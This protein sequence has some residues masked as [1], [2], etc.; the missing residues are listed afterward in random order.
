M[1]NEPTIRLNLGIEGKDEIGANPRTQKSNTQRDTL[2]SEPYL[3]A[4]YIALKEK[5]MHTV[6]SSTGEMTDDTKYR[7]STQV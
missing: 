2:G 7:K 6:V 3:R 1:V 4:I 5:A